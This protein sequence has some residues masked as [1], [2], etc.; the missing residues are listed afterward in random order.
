MSWSI[1]GQNIARSLI[2]QNH[3]VH[4]Q[5]TNGYQH[6][7]KDLEPYVKEKLDPVYDMQLSYTAMRNFP[8]L[9]ANGNKNRFGIWNYETTVLPVGFAKYHKFCDKMLPSSTFANKVFADNGIPKNKLVTVPHGINVDEY[10]SKEIYPLKTNKSKKILSN[11]AQPHIRKNIPGMF[12]A[13]GKAFTKKDDVC[14]V[15]KIS[16]KKQDKSK[17]KMAFDVDFW[18]IYN[19]FCKK[20]PNHAEVEII[21]EFLPSMVPLYNAVDV[22]YSATRAECFNLPM[23]EGMAT[24]NIVISPK[25][26]GHLEFMN[27][28]NSLLIEGKEVRAPKEMQYWS[29][30]PYAAMFEPNLDDAAEKLQFVIKN[31]DSLKDKFLPGMKEQLNK[32]TWDKVTSQIVSLC[33]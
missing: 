11:I 31:Y 2:K 14:L 20:Y 8:K 6:F 13:F 28:N 30:S 21:T 18:R 23:L 16:V 29:S 5:S 17:R 19:E 4:L 25:W 9:L 27:E 32:L 22:V 10:S 15:C 33:E 7:P 26:G 24:N 1:V 12:E 3:E